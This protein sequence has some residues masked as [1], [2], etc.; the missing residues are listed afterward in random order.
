MSVRLSTNFSINCLA[1]NAPVPYGL[2]KLR[3]DL[4]P[5]LDRDDPTRLLSGLVAKYANLK[6][7]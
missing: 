7:L 5:R 3:H 4:Q 2:I 1:A 6:R